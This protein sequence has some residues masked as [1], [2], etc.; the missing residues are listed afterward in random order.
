M[1]FDPA[2]YEQNL[3]RF[4]VSYKSALKQQLGYFPSVENISIE[5][6]Y[7]NLID[8]WKQ[9]FEVIRFNSVP[10]LSSTIRTA[11]DFRN[12]CAQS[13]LADNGAE[14]AYEMIENLSES[15]EFS[16]SK[17]RLRARNIVREV[18]SSD[19]ATIE[20]ERVIELRE[21]VE[22]LSDLGRV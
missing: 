9:E 15:D 11:N 22:M 2:F 13:Y 21:Q 10:Y 16:T 19:S 1:P 4:E 6:N 17:E 5:N 12:F 3:L 8:R 7:N 18:F 20:D 14:Y